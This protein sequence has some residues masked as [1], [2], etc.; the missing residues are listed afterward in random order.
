MSSPFETKPLDL[1]QFVSMEHEQFLVSMAN[2]KDE[3]RVH[4]HIQGLYAA[5]CSNV[6]APEDNMVIF[7]LLAFTHYHFL[8]ASSSAMRCHL[9]EAFASARAAI[10]AA[11]IAAQIIHDRGSQVAYLN[12]TKP[13][14]NYARYLGNLMKDGKPL[15]HALVPHLTK[16]HKT[17]STFASHADVGSFAHRVEFVKTEDG[18]TVLSMQYFQFAR[19]DIERMVHIFQLFHTFVVVLDV[20]SNFLVTEH[21]SV[22]KGWQEELHG[23]GGRIENHVTKLRAQLP[24]DDDE[25]SAEASQASN[26]TGEN[27]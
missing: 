8:L 5:A 9:S 14:D 6:E 10:D 19:N 20:F 27:A 4:S 23:L 2:F 15:P 12:R 24:A 1:L 7:Q 26:P 18:R 25:A 21:K 22:P 16:L 11:L 3:F 17:I 13:F